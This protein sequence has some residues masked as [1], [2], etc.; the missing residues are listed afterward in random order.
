MH[1]ADKP[2]VINKLSNKTAEVLIYEQ[3]G[4]SFFEEGMSAK[5]F[6]NDIKALGD[7]RRIDVRINS[8]GGSVF[9]GLA[10]Y[11]T[12]KNHKATIVAHIDGIALS[13]ASVVAMAADTVNMAENGLM[14]IHN[15]RMVAAGD[16][17]DLRKAITVLSK[18]KQSLL[19]AY[20]SKTKLDSETLSGLLDDETWMTASEA[21]D[22]GFVDQVTGAMDVA[23]RVNFDS[24]PLGYAVPAAIRERFS[25]SD[26]GE[27]S[28]SQNQDLQ[29]QPATLAELKA[30]SGADSDFIV[31]QLEANATLQDATNTLNA[32]LSERLKVAENEL[33]QTKQKLA[34]AEAKEAEQQSSSES[35]QANEDDSEPQEADGTGVEG[36]AALSSNKTPGQALQKP[37][38]KDSL[39]LFE[40][41]FKKLRAEGVS[42]DD[43]VKRIYA[44]Y[45]ETRPDF[46]A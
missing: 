2:Y 37:R 8:P 7:V 9:D 12:L 38:A 40:R 36:L 15:P 43:A 33:E 26:Q 32:Q 17:N 46:A 14:M 45:P 41:E 31:S 22:F 42:A 24:V 5:R 27:E 1:D 34:E 21:A 25:V 18:S 11:N 19:A 29:P 3:I 4:E 30:L 10:I 6:A 39:E 28:M 35:Q 23:A 13:M 20:E 44:Q 16:E